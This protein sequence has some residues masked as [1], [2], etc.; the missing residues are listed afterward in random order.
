MQN[1]T[2]NGDSVWHF[3]LVG[4]FSVTDPFGK[5]C[6]LPGRKDRAVLAFLAAH[7]GRAIARDRLVDLVWPNSIG[8]TGRASL[9]QSLATIRKVL[10]TDDLLTANRDTIVLSK[11][12][13][14]S[15]IEQLSNT[16]SEVVQGVVAP[17]A[18]GEMFLDDLGGISSEY[19]NWRATEQA[20]LTELIASSLFA[21]AERAEDENDL[22][23]SVSCLS[24]LATVD[25]LNEQAIQKLMRGMILAGQP[26]A[27]IQRY[28][29]FE[30]LLRRELNI[31]PA[32]ETRSVLQ[33]AITVRGQRSSEMESVRPKVAQ[34]TLELG[35][36][37][38][39]L[40]KPFRDISPD[41]ADMCFAD[42]LTED[43]SVE[44]GR[45][46][47]LNV[48]AADAGF[49]FR[50][51]SLGAEEISR[52]IGVRYILTG[53][54]RRTSHRLRV[55]AQLHDAERHHLIWAERFDREIRELFD[56]Q[57]D[58]TASVVSAVAPQVEL[59]EE[60]RVS[61]GKI[62]S[63]TLYDR[64]IK[65]YHDLKIGRL[66][67]GPEQV[68]RAISEANSILK[69]QPDMPQALLVLAWGHFYSFL[70]RWPPDPEKSKLQALD[71][72]ER[73]LALEPDNVHA[74][75]VRGEIR[76]SVGEYEAALRDH[77]RALQINPNFTWALFFISMNEALMGKTEEAREHANRG[78]ALSP[79]SRDTG[80]SGAYLALALAS[81][82]DRDLR[83]AI[84]WGELAIETQPNLPFRRLLVACCYGLT[85]DKE[86]ASEH[87][88]TAKTFA[89]GFVSD[90][91]NG[92]TRMYLDPGLDNLLREGLAAL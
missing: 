1:R 44:L 75:T 41:P 31:E 88:Q 69:E 9:R 25:P 52:E 54:V 28:R 14:S 32:S 11:E 46:P 39:I 78:L 86:K 64:A 21:L 70:C 82:A 40:V 67:T 65:A 72:A 7:P 29:R 80:I 20:R 42:G 37:P 23:K 18:N 77:Q 53:T 81:F 79:K 63:M 57:D 10:D 55:V 47:A 50:D 24:Q 71:A 90:F 48:I 35:E 22:D 85:G 83:H 3:Q 60:L 13:T 36:T 76:C 92:K 34:D 38:T 74:L 84:Q 19:D 16:L 43:I 15:D 61:R 73:L 62:K 66:S 51:A 27:A 8:G 12:S 4:A 87:L 56:L 17:M 5:T 49:A 2:F 26:N 33:K 58:I 45:F 68:N 91:R 6:A 30:E 59:S 89:P